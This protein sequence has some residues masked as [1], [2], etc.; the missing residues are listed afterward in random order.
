[1][2]KPD[3]IGVRSG[4]E[5]WKHRWLSCVQITEVDDTLC[6]QQLR[7]SGWQSIAPKSLPKP[8]PLANV[9]LLIADE[10]CSFRSLEFPVDMVAAKDLDEA[11]ALD[12]A[13]WNP[14]DDDISLLSFSERI[15]GHW[16]VAV[17]IWSKQEERR[18]LQRID[19]AV[20]CTHVMPVMAWYIAGT[21][22]KSDILLMSMSASEGRGVFALVSP[23]GVP[24]MLASIASESEARRFWRGLGDHQALLKQGILC[25]DSECEWLSDVLNISKVKPV[26]PRFSLLKRAS[27]QSTVNWLDALYWKKPILACLSLLLVWA[28]ADAAVLTHNTERV[29]NTLNHVKQEALD[30]LQNRD[31][32]DGMQLRLQKY[33][34]LR[35]KQYQPEWLLAALS[36]V[37]PNN[38]WLNTMQGLP[39]WVD[40]YGQ[41]KDVVRLIVLLE[42]VDGIQKVMLLN[43]IQ[44]DARTGLESFQMRLILNRKSS[45]GNTSD[46]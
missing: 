19:Q 28:F 4:L 30:V 22:P 12:V 35:A 37:I 45:L 39:E 13:G 2:D 10:H 16:K 31:D 24:R 20:T 15:A 14:F 44:P 3:E 8:S 43:D 36:K 11:I 5:R 40:I 25:G 17:W 27:L 26:F 38:I 23:A 6:Y 9:V 33:I 18:L 1:V 34:D 32:V 29:Q 41:G 21:Q 46:E 42:K 7:A